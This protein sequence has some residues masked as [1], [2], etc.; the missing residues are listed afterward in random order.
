MKAFLERLER[1]PLRGRLQF[2]F[3][4]ILLL[5]VLLGV[6]SLNVQHL[7]RDQISRLYQ[8]DMLGLVHIETAKS[9]LADMGEYLRQ[10]VLL[11]RGK[12]Q[13]V[14][15]QTLADAETLT[16]QEIELA[17]PLIYREANQRNLADFEGAFSNYNN[18]VQQVVTLLRSPA[19]TAAADNLQAAALLTSPAFRHSDATVKEALARVEQMKRSGADQEVAVATQRFHDYVQ[20]T[21]WLLALV[22][23]VGVLFGRMI[24]VSIRRPA[25]GLRRSLEALSAGEL[26]VVVPYTSYPNEVGELARSIVALQGEA[27]QM[28]AQRWVKTHV[29]AISGELQSMDRAEALANRFLSAVAPLLGIGHGAIYLHDEQAGC[30]R[31]SGSYAAGQSSQAFRLG[32]GLVGQCA[33]ERKAIHLAP[34][35]A[36]YVRIASSLGQAGPA[37]I[38]I[39]PILRG[40]RLLGVLEL[41]SLSPFSGSQRELLDELLP[42]LA[43]NMEI[44]DRTTWTQQLLEETRRQGEVTACQAESLK[45]QTVELEA[46]QETIKA[47][48]AWYRGVIEAAPDGMMI[49]DQ[50]GLI[51]L[52]NPKLEAIFGYASGE[53]N[54]A[55]VEQLVPSIAGV[56]HASLR[57][58]FFAE[59]VSR[60]MGRG[61]VDLHGMRKDGTEFSAE[62]GLSF[63]PELDR[64][65]AC[66]CASVRDVSERR[67]MELAV[68]KSEE[69]LQYILD[70][71]PVCIGVSTYGRL[72]FANPKFVDTF[73]IQVDDTTARMFVDPADSAQIWQSLDA[74]GAVA[75]RELRLFDREGRVRD[76]LASY[77]PIDY[78]GERGLLGWFMDMTDRKAA[79]L[80]MERARDMA[81]EATRSKSDF[82]ANMSHEIRT[83]MNAIIGMSHLALQT[84]TDSRQRGYVEKIQRSADHLLGII[85]DILDFSKIEAGQMRMENVDFLLD[86]VMEHIASI[87]GLKAEEKGLELLF[88]VPND[89]STAFTGD[90]LRLGQILLNLANNAIKFTA[91]G[92]VVIGV[93]QESRSDDGANLHFWVHDT[94]IGMTAEQCRSIFHSFVQGDSSTTRKYGGTG[95]GLTISK[96]LVEL[97]HGR[98]WVES[99]AGN[100]STFHFNVCFGLQQDAPV[101]RKRDVDALVG[102]RVLVVDDNAAARDILAGMAHGFGLDV[103][104]ADSGEQAL[105]LM[106][107]AGLATHPYQLM[108]L[109]WKM[110]GMD[111]IETIRRLQS[112]GGARVPAVVMVTAF[113]RDEAMQEAQQRG[114]AL[115][116]VLSKP[117]MPSV[118]L[119]AMAEALGSRVEPSA[120]GELRRDRQGR[121]KAALA[122][123]RVLLVEDNELNQELALELLRQAGIEVSLAC[124]GQEALDQLAS[125]QRFDGVLMDCQMPV[126]DGYAAARAIREQLRLPDLPIIAM[127]ADAMTGDREKALAAGMNGH[128]SKPLDVDVMFSKMAQWFTPRRAAASE[129]GRPGPSADD[130]MR[131]LPGIDAA[132]ALARCG[133]NMALYRRL[134]GMFRNDYADFRQSF[135]AAR[136]DADASAACRLAHTLRGSAANIGAQAVA[137]AAATLEQACKVETP[138][139]EMERLLSLATDALGP[140]LDGLARLETA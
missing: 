123:C 80:A 84:E 69:R 52:A 130:P 45:A 106:T 100:G 64:R 119:R 139:E 28:A 110:P 83:P 74:S 46:Q 1:L 79:E 21:L 101:P 60:Q 11:G 114:V 116:S 88:Q 138:S 121:A 136:R 125:G 133:H 43:T 107:D 36:D 122:G 109:D 103:D 65:G 113:G 77:L 50:Q 112:A 62:I 70:S 22:I 124:N 4:G 10:A 90:P 42:I 92:T 78:D 40:E 81:E 75:D 48:K 85:N 5:A 98:I 7:Q 132:G 37:E 66:V 12:E 67:A 19:G 102:K 128:I 91:H 87:I 131:E 49:V 137:E 61:N 32:E 55:R 38:A 58:H 34:P 95:L 47:A 15:L 44:V 13:A 41:A 53:L 8:K 120:H 104:V 111:G 118:L 72:R 31:L 86:D 135:Q 73:G 9:S 140:V 89:L 134:L 18:Q 127:T 108:L 71:G 93:E 56:R 57:D 51:V 30:V 59:G 94:G 96:M 6:Y 35:P 3:G 105:R 33:I 24:S 23:G 14:A 2:G 39:L 117:V 25:D 126:M 27:Q 68:Q 63:L 129:T 17:R 76:M 26:D 115:G 54:G 97:M 82:L 99:E 29:A 16:R 20:W